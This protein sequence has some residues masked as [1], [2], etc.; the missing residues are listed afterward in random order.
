MIAFKWPSADGVTRC[1]RVLV[2]LE[3]TLAVSAMVYL[4][5]HLFG[6]AFA[7]S[8]PALPVL[9]NA[10]CDGSPSASSCHVSLTEL[11]RGRYRM[12]TDVPA[13]RLTLDVA[14][15]AAGARARALL[16]RLAQPG[17]AQIE[18]HSADPASPSI[19]PARVEASGLRSVTPLP[20]SPAV[21]SLTFV[22]EEGPEP[23]PFVLDEVGF[24]E[25]DRGLLND[26]RPLFAWIPAVRFYGTLLP[27]TIAR[28]F[29][30]CVIAS[31]VVPG[32][33]LRK[34][35]P[36]LLGCI[37][38]GFCILD[39]A[40]RYSPYGAQDLRSFYAAGPLQRP[41]GENLNIGQWQGFRLL[42][43]QGLTLS[44]VRWRGRECL[45]TA[46]SARWQASFRK[47]DDSRPDDRHDHA[48]GS[49]LQ[50]RARLLCV[51]G[52]P[53]CGRHRPSSRWDC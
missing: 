6:D 22:A 18:I 17:A 46:C 13:E 51:G 7:G 12:T 4:G 14:P 41:P 37:C 34:V 2:W 42:H 26:V 24:F 36:V 20:A 45:A 40:I 53:R 47:R 33:I 16:V 5:F 52:R 38:F 23:V 39:V 48:P 21:M 8:P 29:V 49:F 9:I 50:R 27:W 15:Q 3:F 35:N 10:S 25:E 43:G 31:F 11:Y 32:A 1:A 19:A 28:L 30:F 44:T